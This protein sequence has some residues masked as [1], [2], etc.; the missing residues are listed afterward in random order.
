MTKATIK[1]RPILFS[2]PMVR[3][4]LNG[5]K[6]QTR[7]VIKTGG[8]RRIEI[9]SDEQGYWPYWFDEFSDEQKLECPYGQPGDRLWVRETWRCNNWSTDVATIFYKA[10]ERHSHTEMCEQFPIA[11]H[12]PLQPSQTWEPSIHMP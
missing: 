6:T 1:E 12:T 11:D 3:A 5:N 2:A 8:A 9:E 4:I 10:H 7:R